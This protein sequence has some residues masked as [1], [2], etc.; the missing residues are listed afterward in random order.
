M[1]PGHGAQ[2]A[3]ACVAACLAQ[4]EAANAPVPGR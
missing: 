3:A 4:I 1:A 2:R